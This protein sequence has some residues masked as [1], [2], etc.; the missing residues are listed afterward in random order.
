MDLTKEERHR[1]INQE[2]A[3]LTGKKLRGGLSLMPCTIEGG[4]DETLTALGGSKD[5]GLYPL[6]PP[7]PPQSTYLL[8]PNPCVRVFG[9][10]PRGTAC[11]T[12]RHK[13]LANETVQIPCRGRNGATTETK[14][15]TVCEFRGESHTPT[16]TWYSGLD[17]CGKYEP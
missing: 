4:G 5:A 6:D 1:R 10:G 16:G 15:V 11:L 14:Q 2:R 8:S 7:V 9:P 3:L 13:Q 12:C 17:S